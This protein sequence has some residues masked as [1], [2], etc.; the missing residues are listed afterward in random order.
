[1]ELTPLERRALDAA[2]AGEGR[3]YAA[4]RDQLSTLMVTGR[5][6]TGCGFYTQLSC[7]G[8]D[9]ATDRPRGMDYPGAICDHPG[10]EDCIWFTVYIK[11]GMMVQLEGASSSATWPEDETQVGEIKFHGPPTDPQEIEEF[12]AAMRHNA[13]RRESKKT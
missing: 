10:R 2:L 3:W 13:A 5:K 9:P 6:Y 8:A 11:D 7:E 12:E 4:L 1:M